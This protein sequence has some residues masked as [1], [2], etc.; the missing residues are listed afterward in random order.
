[1]GFCV[2]LVLMLTTAA[3]AFFAAAA[4]LPGGGVAAPEPLLDVASSKA[5]EPPMLTPLE[6]PSQSGFK[7]A[8]TKYKATA[9]VTVCE[10]NNQ[11]LRMKI[12]YDNVAI[13][14][15]YVERVNNYAND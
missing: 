9:I 2:L 13:T 10:N 8:T 14:N 3:E 4:K 15:E 7:V 5:T 12:T 11:N 6:R 1:L